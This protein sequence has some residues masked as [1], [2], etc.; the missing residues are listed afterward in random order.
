MKQF[1]N[2][3][4]QSEMS[5]PFLQPEG[6]NDKKLIKIKLGKKKTTFKQSRVYLMQGYTERPISYYD[7]L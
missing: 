1:T 6:R 2:N 3:S 4:D 5:S 7:Y